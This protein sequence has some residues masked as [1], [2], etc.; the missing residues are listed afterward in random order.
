MEYTAKFD[1][2]GAKEAKNASRSTTQ[3]S[4]S[5]ATGVTIP[6]EVIKQIIE[7]ARKL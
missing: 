6:L 1:I 5:A 3:S 2:Y 4:C 7:R